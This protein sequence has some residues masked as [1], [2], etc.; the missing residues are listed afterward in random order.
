MKVLAVSDVEAK[1]YYDYYAPGKLDEF[2]LILSCGDLR[3]EYLEFLATL[4]HCPVL[5]VHGNH[6][7]GFDKNPPGGCIC[8]ED[9]IYVH[10][11][12]R[13]LGLGGSFRYRQGNHMYTE[14][15]MSARVFRLRPQLWRYKGF[16]IL[17]THAPARG[18]NDM[19]DRA[20]RGFRCFTGLLDRYEPAYFVHGHI[21]RSYGP[22]IPQK[23]V[24]GATTV[25]NACEYCR[26]DL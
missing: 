21:H 26:F 23:T 6:D 4:S 3:G 12:V 14:A 15:Q 18:I 20:H 8:V 17:L 22:N 7:D 10:N 13:V 9:R 25:C 24:R 2:D 11:G 16:D 19:E 1:F 5:Y